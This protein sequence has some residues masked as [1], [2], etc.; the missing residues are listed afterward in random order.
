MKTN[1]YFWSYFAQFFLEWDIFLDERCTENQN[2]HFM[3]NNVFLKS[4][5]LWD[6]VEK[7]NSVSQATGHN[8]RHARY[9]K[10]QTQTHNM[11]YWLLFHCNNR[12]MNAPQCYV[13]RILPVLLMI[14]GML[15][16][17]VRI[18]EG[19]K[20]TGQYNRYWKLLPNY[21]TLWWGW[22]KKCC[23]V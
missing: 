18:K 2:T 12:V 6:K 21:L 14:M 20:H 22:L 16:L 8:T 5:F 13:I 23:Y 17:I 11:Q 7:Y 10:L 1:L 19:H 4:C 9:L 3:F 15:V